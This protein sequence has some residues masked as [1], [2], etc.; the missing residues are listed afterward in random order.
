VL[1][2]YTTLHVLAFSVSDRLKALKE[3]QRG[4]SAVEYALL[5]GLIAAAVVGAVAVF[6]PKLKSLFDGINVSGTTAPAGS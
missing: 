2:L 1:N 5:I 4:A 3:D 6:G